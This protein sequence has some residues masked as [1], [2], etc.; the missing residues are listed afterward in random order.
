MSIKTKLLT[1]LGMYPAKDAMQEFER[2]NLTIEDLD[3]EIKLRDLEIKGKEHLAQKAKR[4][5]DLNAGDPEPADEAARMSYVALVSNT[6]HV[7]RKKVEQLIAYM[8]AELDWSGF[9]DD[10]HEGLPPG[11]TRHDFD[12]LMRGGT[13]FGKL[14]LEW[15]DQMDSEHSANIT[16]ANNTNND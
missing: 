7:Y 8:R 3:R 4:I 11:M 14:F 1:F 10:V 13:N 2:L 16:K 9:N 12:W 15:F 6:S 5:I